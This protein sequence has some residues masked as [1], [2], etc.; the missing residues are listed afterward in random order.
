MPTS[1]LSVDSYVRQIMVEL[2]VNTAVAM[3]R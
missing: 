2:I 3:P 1:K